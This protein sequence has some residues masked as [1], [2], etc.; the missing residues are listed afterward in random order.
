[1]SIETCLHIRSA[2]VSDAATV[3]AFANLPGVRHGTL[4][5]PYDSR[6]RIERR[7]TESSG[8]HLLVGCLHKEGVERIVAYGGLLPRSRRAAHVGE[9]FLIVHDDY[10]GCG[11]GTR[12]LMALL[13][14]ADNWLGLRR[15]ELEVN[16]DNAPAIHIYTQHGF[17]LEGTKRGDAL[18][19]GVLID[20]HIM[21][22]LRE[23]PVRQT[24]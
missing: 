19:N 4:W 22:R 3:A 10:T 13:D 18:R 9:I 17:E 2:E 7:I 5:M 11:Y 15:V 16:V 20:T 24:P 1:M 6:S 23:A 12:L 14:L 8:C 21:G